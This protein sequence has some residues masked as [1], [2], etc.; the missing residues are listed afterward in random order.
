MSKE[1][2]EKLTKEFLQKK[3]IAERM[4]IMR[5]ATEINISK[6]TI[7]KYAKKLDIYK[8]VLATRALHF[9]TKDLTNQKFGELLV[10]SRAPNDSHGKTRWNCKCSCGRLKMINA[11]SL[12][13]KLSKTCG[14]CER[15]N[16]LG[17]EDI[18]GVY[19]RKVR[20]GALGRDLD[21]RITAKDVWDQYQKQKEKCALSSLHIHFET[22]Q[23]KARL[24]TASI[25]RI[26]STKGYTIDNIQIIHKRLNRIK[27]ITP[28]QEFIQW[29][30]A[31]AKMHPCKTLPDS[32]VGWNDR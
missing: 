4:P 7:I 29:C 26:D 22:N 15:K 32:Q 17:F 2:K 23:D 14:T 25:D 21:F 11:A 28:D 3:L 9:K 8:E 19:F 18:S 27:G 30:N 12:I 13:R 5:L 16:F 6:H 1:I 31:V 24:Q 20:Q 10:L